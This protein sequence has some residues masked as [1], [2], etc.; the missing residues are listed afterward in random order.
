MAASSFR[1]REPLS[2]LL[3]LVVFPFGW[4][5]C[6]HGYRATL[7]LVSYFTWAYAFLHLGIF[8]W[9]L[10]YIFTCSAYPTDVI[11]CV[12]VS[13]FS[14]LSTDV[15]TILNSLQYYPFVEVAL[16]TSGYNVLA[17]YVLKFAIWIAF[18]FFVAREMRML[19]ALMERGPI[20]LGNHFEIAWDEG[21][22]FD[23]I[24]RDL[25]KKKQSRFLEDAES[26]LVANMDTTKGYLFHRFDYGTTEKEFLRQIEW[27]HECEKRPNAHGYMENLVENL[28]FDDV[29]FDD[30]ADYDEPVRQATKVML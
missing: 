21:L 3:A 19:A 26:P 24:Y 30:G 18:L 11:K 16:I 14:G 9:N 4:H 2:T 29:A 15:T 10:A 28:D 5:A 8:V 1:V 6:H 20:G 13:L 12:L 22:N 7:A 27:E 17:W 25:G 23:A